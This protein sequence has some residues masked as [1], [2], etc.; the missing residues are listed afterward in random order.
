MPVLGALLYSLLGGLAAFF[1]KFM[2]RKMAVISA[3]I[4]ALAVITGALLLTFNTVISPL[5]Q[6]AF[7]NEVG[8]F[9]GLAF[10][11]VAG[12]CIAAMG[13]IWAACTLYGWQLRALAISVQA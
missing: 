5:A 10:P 2:T 11:P 3:A 13:T 1:V 9:L 12:T 4:T 7:S 8:Q 6:Q